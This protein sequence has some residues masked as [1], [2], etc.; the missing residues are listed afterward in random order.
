MTLISCWQHWP[1][2]WSGSGT[3]VPLLGLKFNDAS[4]RLC[5]PGGTNELAVPAQRHLD[6][7]HAAARTGRWGCHEPMVGPCAAEGLERSL[8]SNPPISIFHYTQLSDRAPA[9]CSIL[10][11]LNFDL[12]FPASVCEEEKKRWRGFNQQ[13]QQGCQVS[14]K[15]A[16]VDYCTFLS[17]QSVVIW[18]QTDKS[19][20]V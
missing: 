5:Q 20:E 19:R 13:K 6:A 15:D 4:C 3:A 11:Y 1:N 17:T 2:G 14:W 8:K 16:G 12:L 10:S 18:E 9:R 7:R